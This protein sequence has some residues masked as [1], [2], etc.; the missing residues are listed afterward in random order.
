MVLRPERNRAE[1]ATGVRRSAT[2]SPSQAV[3]QATEKARRCRITV[4]ERGTSNSA[5]AE[6]RN[7]I[8][9]YSRLQSGSWYNKEYTY[10][11]TCL[12]IY[13]ERTLNNYMH[14]HTHPHTRL[15]STHTP[16]NTR[17]PINTLLQTYTTGEENI[18]NENALYRAL[19]L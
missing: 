17:T 12:H 9:M 2:G 7:E 8:S 10:C 19:V 18:S 6:E 11:L 4:R 5:C 1:W 14:A 3:G 15:H 13:H 16:A